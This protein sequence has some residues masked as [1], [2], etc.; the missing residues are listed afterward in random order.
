MNHG[1]QRG[2]GKG[3]R[4]FEDSDDEE[5]RDDVSS[6]SPYQRGKGKGKQVFE[7][8]YA[9]ANIGGSCSSSVVN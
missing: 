9:S 7:N 4:V 6:T 1:Y 5:D 2:K 3:K 8:L